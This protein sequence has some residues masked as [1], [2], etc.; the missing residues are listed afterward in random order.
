[1]GKFI[2]NENVIDNVTEQLNDFGNYLNEKIEPIKSV[3]FD[4]YSEDFKHCFQNVEMTKNT[5]KSISKTVHEYSAN[6]ILVE[7][8]Y[9]VGTDAINSV[10][11][12]QN[13]GSDVA[14]PEDYIHDDRA[15]VEDGNDVAPDKDYVH[16]DR[17]PAPT[18]EDIAP[19]GT[20]LKYYSLDNTQ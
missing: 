9:N 12:N 16:D 5:L 20:I 6:A 14:P 3:L 17:A 8:V 1:M 19:K 4:L 13:I 11:K 10:I 2:F 7:K 18:L 15:P